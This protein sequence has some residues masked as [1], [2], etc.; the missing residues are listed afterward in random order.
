[1]NGPIVSVRLPFNDKRALA[2]IAKTK[3]ISRHRL[4]VMAIQQFIAANQS[5]TPAA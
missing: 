2:K 3:R 5:E 4:M 1:M